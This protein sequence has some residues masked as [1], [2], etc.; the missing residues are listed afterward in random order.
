MFLP[1]EPAIALLVDS[2]VGIA[3]ADV[4]IVYTKNEVHVKNLI[5]EID[6]TR[7]E[8]STIWH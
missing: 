4:P 8:K 1:I 5:L 6:K 7:P 2:A 3:N